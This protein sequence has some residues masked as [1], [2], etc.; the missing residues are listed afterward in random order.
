MATPGNCHHCEL[1][2]PAGESY[3]LE[4]QGR[5]LPMCCP[6][7]RVVAQVI[8]DSGLGDYYRYRDAPGN[9]P[10]A[11]T[12]EVSEV[13]EAARLYDDPEVQRDFVR[14]DEEGADSV[15]LAVEG[16]TCA[17]CAWLI[18]RQLKACPGVSQ[19]T[20]NL[21]QHR[22]QV[23]WDASR[24]ALSTLL[25]E[26]TKVG[27]RAYP[28]QPDR[29]ELLLREESRR[30][31]RRLGVAGLGMMQVMMYA[32]GLY[33]GAFEGIEDTYR[34]FLRW[35]SFVVTT[36]VVLYAAQP[37]FRACV[38]DLSA[39]QLGMDVPVSLAIVAAYLNSIWATWYQTGEVYF[40]SVCM[41]VFFLSVG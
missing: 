39:G 34:D 7:C 41:F 20:T 3:A 35:V 38:R 19:V 27:Y 2:V 24:V 9:N 6:G 12:Y 40:D 22:V 31:L 8:L 17:A 33:A 5:S 28:F 4:Y 15:I 14:H 21:S 13:L 18:E 1:P 30:A 11:F 36:P 25:Q 37:F 16:I 23:Q 29:Q 10:D 26:V 32:V